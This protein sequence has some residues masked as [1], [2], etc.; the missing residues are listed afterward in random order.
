MPSRRKGED[1]YDYWD[2]MRQLYKDGEIDKHGNWIDHDETIDNDRLVRPLD[3][4]P[5]R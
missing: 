2:R 1:Q 3:P 5:A 4:E